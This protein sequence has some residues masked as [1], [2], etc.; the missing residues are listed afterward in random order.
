MK[1]QTIVKQLGYKYNIGYTLKRIY[2]DLNHIYGCGNGA[3]VFSEFLLVNKSN[4]TLMEEF[5]TTS[6]I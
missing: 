2:D 3:L 4:K 1:I 6:F 5:N